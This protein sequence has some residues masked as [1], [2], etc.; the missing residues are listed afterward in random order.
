MM[1]S[2]FVSISRRGFLLAVA[3]LAP[4]VRAF[5]QAP[6]SVPLD[7]FVELS[8]R[9]L[10]RQSLD[11]EVA[12]IYLKALVT[13]AASAANL[14]NLIDA[15]GNLT[16]EQ[17]ALAGTIV[18]W[19]YT[20]VYTVDGTP[21]LATHTGALMWDALERPAPGTCTGRFGDWSR[22]PAAF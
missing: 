9:L 17:S 19:W 10:R 8:Q 2:T 11:R 21:R 5:A 7:D 18:E 6:V 1:P 3:L 14:A 13:D 12:Q 16:P 4:C 22:P 15:S 20:G